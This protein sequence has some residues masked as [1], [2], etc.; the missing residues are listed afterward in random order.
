MKYTILGDLHCREIWKD[1]LNKELDTSDKVI[2][3]GDYT[4][5]REVNLEDPTDAC[6]F[7]YE[8]LDLKDRYP[9]KIVLLRGNHDLDLLGYHWAECNPRDHKLVR[10]YAQS[11][12]VKGWFLENTQWIYTIPD[13]S[14]ICSHAGISTAWFK[15]VINHLNCDFDDDKTALELINTLEPSELF[16]FTP[17]KLSDYYGTSSSQPCTWIRPQTLIEFGL[18]GFIQVVGHTPISTIQNVRKL[19]EKELEDYGEKPRELQDV[20]CCDSLQYGNYLVIEDNKFIP[21]TI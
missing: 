17:C 15:N 8:I 21:K 1:I 14:I 20:W 10:E 16:A 18:K 12:D 11:G 5:P 9:D 6:G 2:F 7:L 13:T 4:C 3:L 19:A